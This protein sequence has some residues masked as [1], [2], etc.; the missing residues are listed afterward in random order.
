MVSLALFVRTYSQK[1]F[2]D[3]AYTIIC[4]FGEEPV[5]LSIEVP[6]QRFLAY[7]HDFARN[8][9]A[10]NGLI[11]KIPLIRTKIS[12]LWDLNYIFNDNTGL[13]KTTHIIGL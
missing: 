4:S 12:L 6:G 13:S 10:I 2:W 3:T 1:L 11:I 7:F 9:H 8:H 5:K